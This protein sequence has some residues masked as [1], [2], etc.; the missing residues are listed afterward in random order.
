MSM[1][2]CLENSK[3]IVFIIACNVNG[4]ILLSFMADVTFSLTGLT[5]DVMPFCQ[6]QCRVSCFYM[7]IK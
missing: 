5:P 7:H 3:I 2:E 4:H 1:D 6:C